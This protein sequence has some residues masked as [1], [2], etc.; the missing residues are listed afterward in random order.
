MQPHLLAVAFPQAAIDNGDFEAAGFGQ[1]TVTEPEDG[2][3][4]SGGGEGVPSGAIT[5]VVIGVIAI[6]LLVLLAIAVVLYM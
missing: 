1:I 2:A 6:A 5:G 4:E 3:K